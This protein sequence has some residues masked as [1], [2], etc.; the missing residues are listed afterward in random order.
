M[1]S[2]QI[3]ATYEMRQASGFRFVKNFWRQIRKTFHLTLD[4]TSLN[5]KRNTVTSDSVTDFAIYDV[6]SSFPTVDY[7][8][9]FSHG[10]ISNC[11]LISI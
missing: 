10:A 3:A 5:L 9:K 1:L 8:S 6:K 4:L 7:S 11:G 2:F